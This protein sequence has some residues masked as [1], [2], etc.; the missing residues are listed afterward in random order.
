MK[1]A[2]LV[3]MTVFVAPALAQ[4]ADA[5]RGGWMADAGG[6]RHIY[7]LTVRGTA[8]TGTYCT[9]CSDVATLAQIRNGVLTAD[10]LKFEVVNPGPA[11]YRDTVTAKLVADGLEVTRQREGAG[12]APTKVN[13]H[14]AKSE[15]A[16]PP[17]PTGA[18]PRPAYVPPGP[19]EA[20]TPAKVVGLWL[21]GEGPGQQ[22]F[23]FKQNGSELYGLACDP[24]DDPN[25]MAPLDRVS[26]DGTTLRYSIVH[27]N[28]AKAFYDKGP[29]SNDAR[30][31]LA[32]HELH[33]WVIP[34]YEPPS[35]KPIEITMLGPIRG[36]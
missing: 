24:C 3:L 34:S 33:M 20:L 2:L 32:G 36:Y 13:L 30:A 21:F 27:E 4:D 15:P 17:P 19:A 35:F 7:M 22:H 26:I 5:V 25:H 14:R 31:S 29:F 8:V 11:A 1:N 23:M 28:N 12:A 18:P 9:D 10:G 16:A 6:V